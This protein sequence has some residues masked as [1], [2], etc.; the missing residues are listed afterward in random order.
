VRS[1]R[2]L[3]SVIGLIDGTGTERARYA[4]GPYAEPVTATGVN[5]TLP[6][7]PYRYAGEQL[8][9]TGLYK[10]GTRYH[11]P[12]AGRWTQ[13][14]PLTFLAD[15]ASGNR[16]TY[17]VND[18]VNKT[19]P[20]GRQWFPFDIELPSAEQVISAV[21]GAGV[22]IGVFAGCALLTDAALPLTAGLC[23]GLGAAVGGVAGYGTYQYLT[24]EG[25]PLRPDSSGTTGPGRDYEDLD[26]RTRREVRRLASRGRRHPDPAV[27]QSAY[28]WA[29]E[30]L[31]R[32]V[33]KDILIATA[34][35]LV[36]LGIV[37][38]IIVATER[39][40]AALVPAAV[41]IVIAASLTPLYLRHRLA[42]VVQANETT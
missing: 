17:A 37:F 39:E 6:D 30:Q 13:Q 9:T 10:I 23:I 5:G 4:Y 16:Y 12:A 2:S 35:S 1:R 19:D 14:D 33:W 7:N 40:V 36:G 28:R 21:V 26:L 32:P 31:R 15:P 27:S 42:R 38:V 18:P 22:F 34:W 8:D 29:T 25:E 20:T 41:A 24:W 3:G 11:D